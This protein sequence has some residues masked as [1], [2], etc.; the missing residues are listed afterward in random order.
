MAFQFLHAAD[1]HLD[2]PLIGLERYEGA[3][4]EAARGASRR[5]LEN[6]VAL[7]IE[8]RV[9]FV[10]IAGDLY[11]DDWRDFNTG[12]F[13]VGQMTRL[14]EA[15][16]PVY[17]VAG[18]HDAVNK[19][20]RQLH[21]PANVRMFSADQA[22][23]I[24]L[25][26]C[27]VAI[28]GRSYP[29]GAVT[30]NLAI[31]YPAAVPGC[32]NIGLLHTAATGAEGHQPYAPCTLDDLR[33]K[34]YD[35]WAL[36][37]IHKRQTLCDDPY[38]VFSGNI[39]G[40]SVRETGPKGCVAVSVDGHRVTL[41]PCWLDVMRWEQLCVDLS[42][43]VDPGDALEIVR[44]RL[45]E[46]T[47]AAEGRRLAVRL[48]VV[49]NSA[50]HRSLVAAAEQWTNDVRGVAQDVGSG[51]LWLEKVHIETAEPLR[52][53]ASILPDSPQGELLAL[54]AEIRGDAVRLES[55]RGEF[56]DVWERLPVELRD[57]AQ[58][59][60]LERPERL[61]GL[62]DEVEQLLVHRLLT[63]EARS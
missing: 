38:V 34:R 21:L 1:I 3:P 48:T 20:T 35:Y 55:L 23:T 60:G 57:G 5:A 24:V 19:M 10:L 39:Q 51:D 33:A 36:G 42:A 14:R 53:L 12:L 17:V 54:I 32:F 52:T 43:A 22:E 56:A 30:E 7:A 37:H 47:A 45:V 15:G 8:R 62:L 63:R 40:R 27:G 11:D 9:A 49:G 2:S 44:P 16:I 25:D 6:L 28:H 26:E 18:N 31:G 50:A 4:V 61:A 13:F 29:R 59:L 41:E 46:L 58:S